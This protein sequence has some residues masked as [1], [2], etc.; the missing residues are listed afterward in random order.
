MFLQAEDARVLRSQI[1][2]HISQ[3]GFF[4]QVQF[5]M[6]AA[7]HFSDAAILDSH[8]FNDRIFI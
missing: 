7:I 2:D 6:T 4:S 5:N 1:G 8:R 3:V